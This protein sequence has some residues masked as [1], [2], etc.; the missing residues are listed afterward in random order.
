MPSS[1]RRNE[2]AEEAKE[3]LAR[4]GAERVR[5]DELAME[6]ECSPY[7]PSRVFRARTGFS[8]HRYHNRLRVR[9]AQ[10]RIALGQRSLSALAADLGFVDHAHFSRVFHRE[11]RRTPS[12]FRR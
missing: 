10:E 11:T 3:I 7:H 4:R 12:S 2:L 6:L 8:I 5:L 1:R 9:E